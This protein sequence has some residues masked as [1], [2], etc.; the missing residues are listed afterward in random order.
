MAPPSR[1][2]R[3]D[4]LPSHL[5]ARIGETGVAL[6]MLVAREKRV[7]PDLSFRVGDARCEPHVR[8][9]AL[10]QAGRGC[11]LKQFAGLSRGPAT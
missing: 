10:A 2:G 3:G 9:G 11:L 5:A 8:L 7:G 4:D 6:E 1:P